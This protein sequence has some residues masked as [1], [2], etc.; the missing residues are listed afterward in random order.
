MPNA[1]TDARALTARL[2][3]LEADLLGERAANASLRS[4]LRA[5][6]AREAELRQT[7][8]ELRQANSGLRAEVA[9][10]NA[11][12]P[13]S[14]PT[15]RRHNAG[16]WRPSPARR[17][18]TTVSRRAIYWPHPSGSARY[19]GSVLVSQRLRCR[20]DMSSVVRVCENTCA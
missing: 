1:E 10:A 19:A 4:D 18:P 12:A 6:A 16:A 20:A 7:N 9:R 14:P 15:R 8:S 2:R 17:R 13:L 5:S 3:S 11:R